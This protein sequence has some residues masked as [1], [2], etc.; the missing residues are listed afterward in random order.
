MSPYRHS[1]LLS[2]SSWPFLP[3]RIFLSEISTYFYCLLSSYSVTFDYLCLAP[4]LSWSTLILI[5]ILFVF[6]FL[7]AF[8]LFHTSIIWS[9]SFFST[10]L[11]CL[12]YHCMTVTFFSIFPLSISLLLSI[13]LLLTSLSL[14]LD[15]SLKFK[16]LKNW[17]ASNSFK[18]VLQQRH[19]QHP[20]DL[21]L[22]FI[23][24]KIVSF[25][26]SN[27]FSWNPMATFR[28]VFDQQ[29]KD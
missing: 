21:S 19:R 26:V 15:Y 10:P 17:L 4:H 9:I 6:S 7:S 5:S 1:L 24:R 16:H 14:L 22:F 29:I 18:N 2:S 25:R 3:P 28:R 23:W 11:W 12:I 20:I 13:A 8:N 27:S